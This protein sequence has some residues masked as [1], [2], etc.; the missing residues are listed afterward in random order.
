MDPDPVGNKMPGCGA[1]LCVTTTG[2]HFKAKVQH[3][4]HQTTIKQ[5]ITNNLDTKLNKVILLR[6]SILVAS[7]G[8]L[9]GVRLHYTDTGY[10]HDIVYFNYMRHWTDSVFVRTL[11]CFTC[12]HL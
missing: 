6:M 2:V 9:G 8:W 12:N 7:P 5:S 11:S 1:S 4:T 3:V 10:E